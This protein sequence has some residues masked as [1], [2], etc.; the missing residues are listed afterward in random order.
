MTIGP[1]KVPEPQPGTKPKEKPDFYP[2][3][4][5]TSAV[6]AAAIAVA[7]FFDLSKTAGKIGKSDWLGDKGETAFAVTVGVPLTVVGGALVVL[8]AW[9]GRLSGVDDSQSRSRRS[10]SRLG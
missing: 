3:F 8:G 10:R 1:G 5:I 2:V 9:W 7:I 4:A 6:V